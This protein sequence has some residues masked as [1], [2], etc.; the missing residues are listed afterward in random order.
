MTYEAFINR[1]RI[2]M[3]I[4]GVSESMMLLIAGIGMPI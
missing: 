1:V 3:G 4:I 2:L